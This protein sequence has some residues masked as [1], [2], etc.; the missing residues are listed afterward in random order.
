[1]SDFH[2]ETSPGQTPWPS[3]AEIELEKRLLNIEQGQNR[4][5]QLVMQLQLEHR[6]GI[7][8][9]KAQV[10]ALGSDVAAQLHVMMGM[11]KK[12]LANGN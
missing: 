3:E 2:R 1:V 10:S 4:V 9:V 7:N 11:L 6:T 8:E 12:Y 5:S